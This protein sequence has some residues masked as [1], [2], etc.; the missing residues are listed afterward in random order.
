MDFEVGGWP[1][2][3]DGPK[4][5]FVYYFDFADNAFFILAICGLFYK[6]AINT[7]FSVHFVQFFSVAQ[8][9]D[10][11]FFRDCRV[12]YSQKV[13]FNCLDTVLNFL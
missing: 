6:T 1:W 11:L 13:C 3:T 7:E 2:A 4:N 10:S 5:S 12:D 8:G 9:R